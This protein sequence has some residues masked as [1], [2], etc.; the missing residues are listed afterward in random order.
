MLGSKKERAYAL[1]HE[2]KDKYSASQS[3][4][5]NN[6][7]TKTC[8]CLQAFSLPYFFPYFPLL[9]TTFSVKISTNRCRFRSY[10]QSVVKYNTVEH[11]LDTYR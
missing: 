3:A 1:K 11:T 5:M 9:D 10:F 7:S 2:C 8:S 6:I 4:T